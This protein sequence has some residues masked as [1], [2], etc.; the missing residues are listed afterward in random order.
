MTASGNGGRRRFRA[1]QLVVCKV[2]EAEP[3]G[4]RV[5]LW[6][7]TNAFL[8]TKTPLESGDEVVAQCA[9]RSGGRIFLTV[10]LL[11]PDGIPTR[12]PKLDWD[13]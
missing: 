13:V 5:A 2:L 7:E 3:G 1:G 4:Y 9:F 10:S 12:L 8:D 11:P 6:N